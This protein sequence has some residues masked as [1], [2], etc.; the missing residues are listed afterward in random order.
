MKPPLAP[1]P[2]LMY[3]KVGLPV[4]LRAD[5]FLN[6][7]ADSFRRQLRAM[8]HLGYRAQTF[9]AVVH[10]ISHGHALPSRTFCITFDDGYQCIGDVAAP[11]L[12]EF[13]FPATVFVVAD[14]VGG[15]NLWDQ[16]EGRP[17]L[18]LLDWDA[19]RQLQTQGWELAGHTLSHPHLDALDDGRAYTEILQGGQTIYQQTG[20]RPTTFCYP[21]GHFNLRTPGLVLAAGFS[22]ACTTRSGLAYLNMDPFLLPRV[23]VGYR[24]RV[25]GLL[26]RLMICPHLPNVRRRRRSEMSPA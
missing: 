23:K 15:R 26:Y 6:V 11:I 22:G 1:V 21:F 8:A 10:A 25:T 20:V 17:V 14:H 24:D 19:L 4:E 18:P 7:S 16:Q 9:G 13:G 3:H 12:A 2:I 5:T